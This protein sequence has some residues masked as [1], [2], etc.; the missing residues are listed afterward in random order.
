MA[1]ENAL[2][3]TVNADY[4]AVVAQ[5]GSLRDEMSKLAQNVQSIANSKAH[6][7][8]A[9]VADGMSEAASYLGRKSHNAEARIEG[10]VSA[11]PYIALGLAAG[12]G[13]LLGAMARR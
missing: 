1:H 4:D 13:L 3:K 11:N 2:L 5:M 7:L 10:A 12:M 8:S 9:D 6:A